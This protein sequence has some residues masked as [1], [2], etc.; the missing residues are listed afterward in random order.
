MCQ[1]LCK[2]FCRLLVHLFLPTTLWGYYSHFTDEETKSQRDLTLQGG[3]EQEFQPLSD[4]SFCSQPYNLG[5]QGLPPQSKGM[6]TE[7]WFCFAE[8]L[9]I[10]Q[11]WEVS[12]QLLCGLG[13]QVP[14]GPGNAN[15]T[16]GL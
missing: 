2:Q 7:W 3:A 14:A 15:G 10:N 8:R 6:K 5:G 16:Q 9:R 11:A 1:A 13:Q 12:L 4:Q